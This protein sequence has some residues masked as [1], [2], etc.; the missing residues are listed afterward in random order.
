MSE[1]Q[2][3]SDTSL[4]TVPDALAV[5]VAVGLADARGAAVFHRRVLSGEEEFDLQEAEAWLEGRS[6]RAEAW[7]DTWQE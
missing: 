2:H 7:Q 5:D 1:P 4:P 6:L 3:F